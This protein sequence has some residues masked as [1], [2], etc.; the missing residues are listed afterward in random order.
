MNPVLQTRK[1][2]RALTLRYCVG[3][4]LVAII[5]I[6]GYAFLAQR[7]Q[8]NAS[9][10]YI[11][12]TAGMQR[13]LSQR[14]ALS[15][16]RL[17]NAG[18]AEDADA[19]LAALLESVQTMRRNHRDL[20][21][22][23]TSDGNSDDVLALY[24]GAAGIDAKVRRYTAAGDAIGE[25]FR[26]QGAAA[27][28]DSAAWATLLTTLDDGLL[29]DL[30]AVVTQLQRDYEED[31]R[32]FFNLETLIL[33]LGLVVLLMEALLI[34]RPIVARIRQTMGELEIAN[35]ELRQ[36]SFRISHDLRA[37][38]ASSLGLVGIARDALADGNT[39]IVGDVVDRIRQ[40]MQRLDKLIT[41]IIRVTRDKHVD[42][43]KTTV[44]LAPMVDTVFRKLRTMPGAEATSLRHDIDPG[45]TLV[46]SELYL[47]QI[48]E[49][50]VS[51]AVKYGDPDKAERFVDVQLRRDA[52]RFSLSVTDNGRGIPSNYR[53]HLFGM[54]KRFHPSVA[55]G[56]GLGLYLVRQNAAAIDARVTYSPT[57]DG[58][59]FVLE[60]PT[61]GA[62]T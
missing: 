49:N 60:L 53:Q 15:A 55:A 36:F 37:P 45:T 34:F 28:V 61:A 59:T 43:E 12:N 16:T 22:R 26:E 58:S 11:I 25:Q 40:S 47:Q 24:G 41:D 14:I 46:T 20:Y 2:Q 18:A 19:N 39:T 48:L 44:A 5:L 7:L 10:A 3:L 33:A 57:Q 51:N 1:L 54:F 29:S 50:L 4:A 52:E 27:I 30:D 17:A 38:I 8:A 42:V 35:N 23:A 13:M 56:T 32:N 9:D 21:Q 31:I 6:S 62:S